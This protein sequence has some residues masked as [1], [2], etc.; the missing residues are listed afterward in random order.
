MLRRFSTRLNNVRRLA[1]P[2]L[3]LRGITDG[4]GSAGDIRRAATELRDHVARAGAF[5]VAP[6]QAGVRAARLPPQ[7]TPCAPD[8]CRR[9]LPP[10]RAQSGIPRDARRRKA[11]V[12]LRSALRPGS[13]PIGTTTRL[14]SSHGAGCRCLRSRRTRRARK[15]TSRP[16]T[17]PTTSLQR[18]RS[19]FKRARHAVSHAGSS[20]RNAADRAQCM[21][22]RGARIPAAR[23]RV[24]RPVHRA[25]ALHLHGP[26]AHHARPDRGASGCIQAPVQPP[27]Y[28][29]TRATELARST[30]RLLNYPGN[31]AAVADT[32]RVTMESIMSMTA[33]HAAGHQRAH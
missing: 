4:H 10:V 5:A 24:L 14:T 19:P 8:L 27:Q 18:T 6:S 11:Q 1:V 23:V 33:S 22:G 31:S 16:S 7:M 3:D 25:G 21:A 20:C 15:R 29:D 2:E 28:F 17:W 30:M 32:A 13:A 9:H 12:G 26:G